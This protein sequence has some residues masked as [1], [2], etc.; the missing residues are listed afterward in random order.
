MAAQQ[1]YAVAIRSLGILSIPLALVLIGIPFAIL[2]IIFGILQITR[3]HSARALAYSGIVLSLVALGV[4]SVLIYRILFYPPTY[5]DQLIRMG[6]DRSVIDDPITV[7]LFEAVAPPSMQWLYSGLSFSVGWY[8]DDQEGE[9]HLEAPL[10]GTD[11]TEPVSFDPGDSRFGFF[12]QMDQM[13]TRYKWYTES[14]KNEGVQMGDTWVEDDGASHVKIYP[15]IVDG[16][17]V[18]NSYLLCWEDFPLS[19][20]PHPFIDFTDL[21]VRVDGVTPGK[22][23]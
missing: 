10:I 6:Y 23:E 13:G 8:Q 7:E 22:S 3:R 21:I 4:V 19:L 14:A 11:P 16:R 17:E 2:G 20:A 1:I 9:I 5:V 12:I 15:T 18:L